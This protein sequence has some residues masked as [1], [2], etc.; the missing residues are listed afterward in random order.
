MCPILLMTTIP[1]TRAQGDEAVICKSMDYRP[2][3]DPKGQFVGFENRGY[4]REGGDYCA[5]GALGGDCTYY[6]GNTV[7]YP[8]TLGGTTRVRRGQCKSKGFLMGQIREIQDEDE[9]PS[10]NCIPIES[11]CG[12]FYS[13]TDEP[14]PECCYP[15]TS[16][17]CDEVAAGYKELS[18]PDS[19]TYIVKGK[20]R[21]CFTLSRGDG[22][23]LS[24]NASA[25][26]MAVDICELPKS[27]TLRFYGCNG[28]LGDGDDVRVEILL[29]KDLTVDCEGGGSC[30]GG[31]NPCDQGDDDGGGAGGGGAGSSPVGPPATPLPVLSAGQA[32]FAPTLDGQLPVSAMVAHLDY[33][34]QTI[35]FY[36]LP[37]LGVVVKG[38]DSI[39]ANH[40]DV[41]TVDQELHLYSLV[42]RAKVKSSYT[43]YVFD[44]TRSGAGYQSIGGWHNEPLNL[45]KIRLIRAN[46]P[47]YDLVVCEETAHPVTGEYLPSYWRDAS[48]SN[49]YLQFSYNSS[50]ILTKVQSSEG[51]NITL[52]YGEY[53]YG[54]E[55]EMT[56]YRLTSI[57]NGCESCPSY[58]YEYSGYEL[59][60]VVDAAGTTVA[61]YQYAS[62]DGVPGEFMTKA[63]R[64]TGSTESKIYEA[65]YDPEAFNVTYY[66]FADNTNRQAIVDAYD[67][68]F[69]TITQRS[70]YRD[71]VTGAP[72]GTADELDYSYAYDGDELTRTDLTLPRGNTYR[73]YEDNLYND[74]Y[75]FAYAPTAM[76][77][78]DNTNDITLQRFS[79]GSQAAGPT[80]PIQ[81]EIDVRGSTTEYQ[82]DTSGRVMLTKRIDPTVTVVTTSTPATF[83]HTTDYA[84][85]NQ[86]RLTRQTRMSSGGGSVYTDYSY[87]VRGNATAM[88]EDAGGAV[89]LTTRYTYDNANRLRTA[90][91]PRGVKRVSGYTAGGSLTRQYTLGAGSSD[92]L[93][94]RTYEYDVLG[95][96]TMERVAKTDGAISSPEFYSEDTIATQFVYDVYGRRTSVIADSGGLNLTATYEYDNLDRVVKTTTP[97]GIFTQIDRD[98]RGRRIRQIVGASGGNS[99]TT[100][101]EYDANSNLTRVSEPSGIVMT[102]DYDGFD[103]RTKATRSAS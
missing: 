26:G 77:H 3:L 59:T 75:Q 101:Y 97:G 46:E 14:E 81:T 44:N 72:A 27:A 76:V 80:W 5:C 17:T 7:L 99:L 84:Y 34:N 25:E 32:R 52:D 11:E 102:Y 4:I 24:V 48:D 8:G 12:A 56:A 64:K 20:D 88:I 89:P 15:G 19:G 22:G 63:Y 23:F 18:G 16:C 79:Y 28:Q 30:G 94:L 54:P 1:L 40:E 31:L 103:R 74:Q 45:S 6:G 49:I 78:S 50:G 68:A 92:A 57:S 85:D 65:V 47:A 53:I 71:L 37:D 51:P 9:V 60:T 70:M 55:N 96:M 69:G 29:V 33:S 100:S 82:Y 87:D 2:I 39:E 95:R 10:E 61:G 42:S 83:R 38:L 62:F 21:R 58:Q 73:T 13:C 66:S 90:E 86:Y 91:D 93:E 98:G 35:D 67:G 36:R 41:V 43:E